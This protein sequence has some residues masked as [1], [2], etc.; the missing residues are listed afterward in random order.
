MYH[1][2]LVAGTVRHRNPGS[3]EG[4]SCEKQVDLSNQVMDFLWEMLWREA[5]DYPSN[6][7][8]KT[9]L[10]TS[11][12]QRKLESTWLR[13]MFSSNIRAATDTI[14][15]TAWQV[16]I[17]VGDWKGV[18]RS[19]VQRTAWLIALVPLCQWVFPMRHTQRFWSLY[20]H[21]VAHRSCE[22][23]LTITALSS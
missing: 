3:S 7:C 18:E 22:V 16:E 10:V 6:A 4:R 21:M 13:T 2:A 8:Q 11:L 23:P 12:C 15:R 9:E 14:S 5:G 1:P 20:T 19:I 17:T